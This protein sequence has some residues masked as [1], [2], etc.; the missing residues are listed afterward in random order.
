MGVEDAGVI[1]RCR[2]MGL[3]AVDLMSSG[4]APAFVKWTQT[5]S[6]PAS[7]PCAMPRH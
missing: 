4:R 3:P 7:K 5:S 2:R 6:V 1:E